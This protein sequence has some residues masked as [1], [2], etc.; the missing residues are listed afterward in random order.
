MMSFVVQNPKVMRAA[1]PIIYSCDLHY[2]LII[3]SF[4]DLLKFADFSEDYLLPCRF[5]TDE[6]VLVGSFGERSFMSTDWD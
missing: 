1:L 5:S 3:N 4:T 6:R 2:A